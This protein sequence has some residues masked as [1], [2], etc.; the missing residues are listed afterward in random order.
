M[1]NT[2]TRNNSRHL[3]KKRNIFK[4]MGWGYRGCYGIYIGAIKWISDL[5]IL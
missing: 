3:N 1:L 2:L 5:I 4:E